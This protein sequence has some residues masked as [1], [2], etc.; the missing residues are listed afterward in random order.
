MRFMPESECYPNKIVDAKVSFFLILKTRCKRSY[1]SKIF[2]PECPPDL[3]VE[4]SVKE[5]TFITH[6]LL[7]GQK[8]SSALPTSSP[9]KFF[10]KLKQ[11]FKTG[12]YVL[13]FVDT[14]ALYSQTA[15]LAC[16]KLSMRMSQ[17][18]SRSKHRA[19]S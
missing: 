3:I 2:Q 7:L 19:Q 17:T 12:Y 5:E 9:A 4:F 10:T 16:K 6:I 14:V 11:G 18:L 8:A 1:P 13:F 15:I